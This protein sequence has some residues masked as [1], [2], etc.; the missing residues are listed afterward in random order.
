MP[1]YKVY[2]AVRGPGGGLEPNGT[3]AGY[4]EAPS[5]AE[6]AEREARALRGAARPKGVVIV[7]EGKDDP[8]DTASAP[9]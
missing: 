5:A 1:T 8:T 2:E 9:C 6:A 7:A 4:V 3:T